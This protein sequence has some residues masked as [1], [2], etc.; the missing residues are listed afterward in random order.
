MDEPNFED[1]D[2]HTGSE[3]AEDF[4]SDNEPPQ[5]K[6]AEKK[7]IYKGRSF[8]VYKRIMRIGKRGFKR[9]AKFDQVNFK[10]QDVDNDFEYME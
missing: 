8:R 3:F 6:L 4:E 7:M 5:D 9:P 10:I 2:Y 1:S